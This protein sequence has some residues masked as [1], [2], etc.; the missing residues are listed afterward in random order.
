MSGTR[1]VG[2]YRFAAA[3]ACLALA[4]PGVFGVESSEGLRAELSIER[5]LLLPSDPVRVRFTLFNTG[6]EPI[7]IAGV[8]PDEP[9][10]LPL[11]IVFGSS[12]ESALHSTFETDKAQ[13]VRPESVPTAGDGKLRLAPRASLGAEVDLTPLHRDFRYPGRFRLEWRPLGGKLPPATLEF[14]IESRKHAIF[15]TDYGKLTFS[16][17]YEKA[18]R[19]VENFLEL[20]RTH[21]YDGT[22]IS[23]IV[24]GFMIQGGAPGGDRRAARPDGRQI[25]GEFH[26]APIDVGTL[27]MARMKNDP[28][29]A[30]CQWFITLARIEEMDGQYSVIGQAKDEESL[31]TL[32]AI[33][34]LPTRRDESPLRSVILRNV[35]LSEAETVIERIDA[36][37]PAP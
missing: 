32:R 16:M 17:F 1:S 35:I 3:W 25:P 24:P 26:D 29:S 15:S 6:S 13:P 33:A 21:F 30:S 34:E 2:H 8:A 37:T 23:R 31:R 10:A 20:A 18:P 28:N 27:V 7:E 12:E 14:R 9:I 5:V 11:G 22:P 19:N 4:A 36:A